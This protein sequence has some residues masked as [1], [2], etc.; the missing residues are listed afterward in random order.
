MKTCGHQD[1][2]VSLVE[3]LIDYKNFCHPKSGWQSCHL[4]QMK[5]Q[6]LHQ[7]FGKKASVGGLL[8][9]EV[10]VKERLVFDPSIWELVGFTDLDCSVTEEFLGLHKKG[11]ES[12]SDNITSDAHKNFATH[13]LQFHFKSLFSSFKYPCAFFMTRALN[14]L[15]LQRIFWQG[16]SMLHG[17]GFT[18]LFTG[19]DGASANRSFMVMNGVTAENSS[20]QNFF[21]RKPIFFISDPPHLLKKL[22]NNLYNSGNR[23]D[24]PRFTRTLTKQGEKIVWEHFI[25]VYN[26]DKRRHVC[27]T[28]LRKEHVYLDSLS[29]MRVKLAVQALSSSVARDMELHDQNTTEQTTKYIKACETAWFAFNDNKKLDT[30]N[31]ERFRKLDEVVSFF[32]EWKV[33]I[34]N[35]Y[36]T[37]AEQAK[38][39]ITWQTMFDLKVCICR[40]QNVFNG[41]R[42]GASYLQVA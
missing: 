3:G 16:V 9:N 40:L 42:R 21:S 24:N 33:E 29:K 15:A 10:Q 1:F 34:D 18:T 17:C 30:V 38:H 35:T 22:R 23:E 14:S 11:N 8:F 31:D 27:T 19:C 28:K 25:R 20:G 2:C 39:F 5:K 41:C 4:L 37:K 12:D 26:R 13:V 7:K 6:F 32:D 36:P